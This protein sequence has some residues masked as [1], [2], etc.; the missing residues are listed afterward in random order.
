VGPLRR[1]T[2]DQLMPS[3]I[4][5]RTGPGQADHDR[6]ESPAVGVER[7]CRCEAASRARNVRSR[8]PAESCMGDNC[9]GSGSTFHTPSPSRRLWLGRTA[10]GPRVRRCGERGPL[11]QPRDRVYSQARRGHGP[12]LL[13]GEPAPPAPKGPATLARR[14]GRPTTLELQHPP[15]AG[16]LLGQHRP[17]RSEF[18]D[19]CA[20]DEL[21]D[22]TR[23]RIVDDLGDT[24]GVVWTSECL[25]DEYL[26]SLVPDGF[27]AMLRRARPRDE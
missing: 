21:L 12:R 2:D 27:R 26:H 1:S 13:C 6:R 22:A 18:R 17:A 7:A 14:L 11:G 8:T 5:S 9:D 19:N 4:L 24:V 16:H 10:Y 3:P 23:I 20:S 25:D 15:S